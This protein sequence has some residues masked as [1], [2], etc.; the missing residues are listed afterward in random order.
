MIV[1]SLASNF[2]KPEFVKTVVVSLASNL[3][4]CFM[5]DLLKRKV[6]S[7][8]ANCGSLVFA[9]AQRSIV[10]ANGAR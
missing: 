3:P 8:I 10:L 2:P 4:K 6:S 7:Y 1:V 9:N 5:F